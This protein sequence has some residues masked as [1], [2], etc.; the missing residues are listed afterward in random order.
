MVLTD[1]VAVKMEIIKNWAIKVPEFT[2][3][4]DERYKKKV[5][6]FTMYR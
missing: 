1:D 3:G 5:S 2:D 4:I 6:S